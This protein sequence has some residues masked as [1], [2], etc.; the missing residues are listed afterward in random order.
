VSLSPIAGHSPTSKIFIL[1]LPK[2]GRIFSK[3]RDR[4]KKSRLCRG[5][6]EIPVKRVGADEKKVGVDENKVGVDENKVGVDENKVGADGNKVGADG[7]KVGVDGN[8][9]GAD[10]EKVGA[11]AL[12]VF[13]DRG[14]GSGRAPGSPGRTLGGNYEAA[15]FNGL[16]GNR[17]DR[18]S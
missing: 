16:P 3:S 17:A 13:G 14:R 7:N 5:R 9:V 8:K 1:S 11:D 10:L 12:G 18:S 15:F 2:K 4:G 6:Q